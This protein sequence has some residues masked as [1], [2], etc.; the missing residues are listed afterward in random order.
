MRC[1]LL[2]GQHLG[3][4]NQPDSLCRNIDLFV[5]SVLYGKVLLSVSD[6]VS[7]CFEHR[8]KCSSWLCNVYP[9]ARAIFCIPATCVI[10]CTSVDTT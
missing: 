7:L 10:C 8:L 6:V 3:S 2:L 9:N 5:Y 1:L 4:K